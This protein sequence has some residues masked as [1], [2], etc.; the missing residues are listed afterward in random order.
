MSRV[1]VDANMG[2][3]VA[4]VSDVGQNKIKP[5]LNSGWIIKSTPT[6]TPTP[7]VVKR[8]VEPLV[9]DHEPEPRERVAVR[10]LEL[11][12][13]RAEWP[14]GHHRRLGRE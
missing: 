5:Q 8:R 6:K 3:R 7:V 10:P 11:E 2:G 9:A 12:A 1:R 4:C 14:G 13:G